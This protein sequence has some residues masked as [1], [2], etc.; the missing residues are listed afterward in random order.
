M[1]PSSQTPYLNCYQRTNNERWAKNVPKNVYEFLVEASSGQL[2]DKVLHQSYFLKSRCTFPEVWL[3]NWGTIFP[4][5]KCMCWRYSSKS[6]AVCNFSTYSLLLPAR[7]V[8]FLVRKMLWVKHYSEQ[9]RCRK[10]WTVPSWSWSF[11]D[12]AL[13]VCEWRH[14]HLSKLI[15]EVAWGKL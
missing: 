13:H 3:T 5:Q 14:M 12:S 1:S 7:D 10:I 15:Y 11:T 8:S 9:E 2:G 6:Q 4:Y